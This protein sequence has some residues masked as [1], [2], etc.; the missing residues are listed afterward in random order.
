MA[1]DRIEETRSEPAPIVLRELRFGDPLRWLRLGWRD[2]AR[3]PAIGLFYGACFVAM[4]W[5]LAST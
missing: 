5:A 3:C 2:F 4:G 1:E